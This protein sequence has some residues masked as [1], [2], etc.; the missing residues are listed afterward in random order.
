MPTYLWS[1]IAAENAT[2]DP[3]CPFPEGQPPSSL[4]DG[5]RGMMAAEARH[6]ADVSGSISTSSSGTDTAYVLSSNS[7]YTE[8]EQLNDQ[9]IAF[10]PNVTN[11]AGPVT[12]EVDGLGVFPIQSSPGVTLQA[13]VLIQGTPYVVI[14]NQS[15]GAFYLMGSYGNAP[16]TRWR[17]ARR[18]PHT[19]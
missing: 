19:P 6:D 5:I 14:F 17:R 8:L 10:S 3:T 18:E 9:I 11:G 13:G 1:Q 15:A 7:G 2:A 12:L 16:S 4:N